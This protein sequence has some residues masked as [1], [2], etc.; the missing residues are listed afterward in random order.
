MS[1]IVVFFLGGG[2][3]SGGINVRSLSVKHIGRV[4]N[5]TATAQKTSALPADDD[6]SAPAAAGPKC[7]PAVEQSDT[8]VGRVTRGRRQDTPAPRT[9]EGDSNGRD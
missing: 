5:R 9:C 1:A 8:A 3:V 4:Q 2:Q 7:P 6:V